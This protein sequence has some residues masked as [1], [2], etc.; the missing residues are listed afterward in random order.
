MKKNISFIFARGGSKGIIG[1]NLT[2]FLGKPL[3]IHTIEFAKSI[4]QISDIFV[5]SDDKKILEVAKKNGVKTIKRPIS[6]SLDKSSEWKAWQHAIKYVNK[7]YGAFNTFISLPTTGP[8]RKKTDLLNGLK[9]YNQSKFDICISYTKSNRNP[10]F[11]MVTKKNNGELKIVNNG[12]NIVTRQAAP[13]T[14]DITTLFYI[15]DPLYILNNTNMFEGRV[16][17]I[18]IPKSRSIDIDDIQD[19]KIAEFLTRK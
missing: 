4:H 8:L 14:Y 10:Y 16:T 19:L 9:K 7:E 11:N 5:S 17:G 12:K 15:A 1:K 13:L 18:E 6:L 2:S 3:I